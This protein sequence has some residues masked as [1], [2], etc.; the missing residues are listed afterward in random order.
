MGVGG[1]AAGLL[2]LFCPLLARTLSAESGPVE[3]RY[4]TVEMESAEDGL[5]HSISVS[6]SVVFQ[7]EG[8]AL[9]L[10]AYL[11]SKTRDWVLA[12]LQSGGIAC[13]FQYR[14]IELRKGRTPVLSEE[15]G[16]CGVWDTADVRGDAVIVKIL[17]YAPHP[18]LLTPEDLRRIEHTMEVFTW[19]RGKL[20]RSEAMRR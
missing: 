5:T 3:T 4:G 9:S 10:E 8:L 1:K 11:S 6:G 19:S 2:L 7:Y 20:E 18:E 16:S 17:G 12:E 14:L 13:P 15:F